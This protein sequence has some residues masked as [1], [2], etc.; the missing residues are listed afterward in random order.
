M[1]T[2]I[3]EIQWNHVDDDES[4]EP[5]KPILT[6]VPSPQAPQPAGPQLSVQSRGKEIVLDGKR[7]SV[8]LRSG[9]E[10]EPHAKIELRQDDFFLVNLKTNGTRVRIGEEETLCLD[11]L[12][13]EGNGAISLGQD[14]REGSPEVLSFSRLP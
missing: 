14:F 10:R 1:D 8:T 7:P 2:E 12:M 5:K 13:L 6:S 4:P 9:K 11:E 3:F